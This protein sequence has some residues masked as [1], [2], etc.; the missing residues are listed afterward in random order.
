MLA[1]TRPQLGSLPKT[2]ALNRLLRATERATSTASSSE[3][4]LSAVIAISWSAPSAS[5][6]SCIARSVQAWV[7][8]SAKS[9]GR[10]GDPAGAAG[11]HGDGVVGGHAAVGV[12]PVE[13]D[14]GGGAERGVELG[15]GHHGVGGDHHEHGGQLRGQHA[16]ALG[17]PADAPAGALDVHLL[18][19][20]VGGHDRLGGVLPTIGGRGRRGPRRRRPA[21]A[22]AGWPG[23]SGR[24]SRRRRRPRRRR[25]SP[26]PARRPRG[27]SGSR[28][29]R[30]SSWRRRS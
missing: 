3:A 17:H 11:Q 12:E 28:R 24:W 13:A 7:S 6:S 14:P 29:G 22:R 20:R 26:P 30:C 8:A 5:L 18:A 10:R 2:A 23:R 19:D 16:G 1:S 27:W 25:A 21:P 9:A 15:G 4:A